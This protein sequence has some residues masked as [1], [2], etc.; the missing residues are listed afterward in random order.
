MGLGYGF[1]LARGRKVTANTGKFKNGLTVGNQSIWA[2]KGNTWHVDSDLSSASN[3]NTGKNW[4]NALATL[5]GARSKASANDIILLAPSHSESYTTTGKKFTGDVAG[6]TIVSLG[7][8]SERATFNFGHTGA[9]FS[10]EAANIKFVN[11]LLVTAVDSVVKMMSIAAADCELI[12]CESRDAA[13][14]EVID[15]F[16]CTT[17]AARLKVIGHKH[18]GDI[19]SGD[20]NE[21]IFN[22]TD[23]SNFEIKDSIFITK[24]GTGVVEIASTAAGAVVD[25]CIFYVDGTSDYSL[26]IV[27]TDNDSTIV[28]RNCFDLEAMTA[29][30]G[31]NNGDGFS[32][33]GDDVGALAT[34]IGALTNT[35][36]T[37]TLT[38]ILGDV[39]NISVASQLM[40][41]YKATTIA[42]GTTIPN[43]SQAAGGL[44]AT[45][46]GGDIL[47]EEIIWQRGATNFEGPTN[48][49]FSTDNVAGLTGAAAPVG[50]ALLVK[51]NAATTNI[52]SLDG[53]TKQLPF[54]LESGKKLYIHG[55]DAATSA[56]GTT[57][58]YIKYKRLAA[59]A[60]L[61]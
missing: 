29:F 35:G 51:F 37:A 46:T 40:D 47:I 23:V 27:D 1:G 11:C 61:A 6:L 43:N 18:I 13:G 54:V 44:L 16:V 12:G 42:D 48:Y 21:S 33:A 2:G 28:V 39:K 32:V 24:S 9:Y 19:A 59:G 5:D 52:L 57:N 10:V 15:A 14:K 53:S 56:G 3:S 20:A 31:G 41:G 7:Q 50:V 25:N 4:A 45:A 36:G 26:N 60:Y 58:F 22:L 8:G 49:E 55:D 17:A 38:A 30:S 34:K